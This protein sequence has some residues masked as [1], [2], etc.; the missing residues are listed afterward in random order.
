[1]INTQDFCQ[2]ISEKRPMKSQDLGI[3]NSIPED[4][5]VLELMERLE[6][7]YKEV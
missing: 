2:F 3:L 1:M 6:S 4:L 5:S 7:E